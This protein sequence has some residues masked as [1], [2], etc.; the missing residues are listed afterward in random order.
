MPPPRS[1]G[2]LDWASRRSLA[3]TFSRFYQSPRLHTHMHV[4]RILGSR[5]VLSRSRG[6]VSGWDRLPETGPFQ[7]GH[8]RMSLVL[9]LHMG[10]THAKSVVDVAA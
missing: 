5:R 7:R 6:G 8:T 1:T 3:L 10:Q 4:H 9:G 2:W